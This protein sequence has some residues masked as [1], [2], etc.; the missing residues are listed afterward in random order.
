MEQSYLHKKPLEGFSRSE[1]KVLPESTESVVQAALCFLIF[2]YT[3]KKTVELPVLN[4]GKLLLKHW[5]IQ[6]STRMGDLIHGFSLNSYP[7]EQNSVS[8]ELSVWNPLYVVSNGPEDLEKELNQVSSTQISPDIIFSISEGPKITASVYSALNNQDQDFLEGILSHWLHGIQLLESHSQSP[9]YGLPILPE[10]EYQR[11]IYDWNNNVQERVEGKFDFEE[12][13][14]HVSKTPN[15]IAVI[16]GGESLTYRELQIRANQLAHYLQNKG[17]GPEVVAGIYLTRSIEFV[18][19]LVALKKSG[20]AFLPLDP[21]HP[22]DRKEYLIKNSRVPFIITT[23]RW[24]DSLPDGEYQTIVLEDIAGE[25]SKLPSHSPM[26]GLKPGNMSYLFFTSGSTGQP[27]GVM[28]T[29]EYKLKKTPIKRAT[30]PS[31]TEKVLLKSSTGFT[32]V[33]LETFSPL[34][35]GGQ[36]VVVPKDKDKDPEWLVNIIQSEAVESLCL[37]P[38]MLALLLLQKGF[39]QCTSIKKVLTVGESLPVSVQEDF[40]KALPQAQLVVYYGCT[41]APSATVRKIDPKEDYGDRVVLGKANVNR[42]I[43][44]LDEF[45]VPVPIGVPGE[46]FIGGT[47]SRGYIHNESLTAERFIPDTFSKQKGARMYQTGDL[48]R[49]LTD[50]SLEYI[51]RTDF[52][53]QIR[54]IRIEPGEIEGVLARHPMVQ[55]CVVLARE[56][57]PGNKQ[58]VA[59]WLAVGSEFPTSK[60]L[61]RYLQKS[62]PEYM[63]PSSFVR[64]DSFPLT[65]NGKIDRLAF[66]RPPKVNLDPLAEHIQ[67]RTLT[68]ERIARI[69]IKCLRLPESSPSK[70]PSQIHIHDNFFE[71]GGHSLIAAQLINQ[72][73]SDLQVEMPINQ[74]FESPTIAQLAAYVEAESA[75]HKPGEDKSCLVTVQSDGSQRPFFLVPGGGGGEAELIVYSRLI[76]LLGKDQP[77]YG[78][79]AHGHEGAQVPYPSVESIAAHYIEA[80]STIQPQGPYLI[81]GECIGGVVAY[82]MAQQL[83]AE[84]REVGL[85]V[86][87]DTIVPNLKK[88]LRYKIR[89][90]FKIQRI[91]IHRKKLKSLPLKNRLRYL[92]NLGT[93]T[94]KRMAEGNPSGHQDYIGNILKYRPQPYSGPITSIVTE[95]STLDIENRNWQNLTT[96]RLEIHKVP[97]THNTYLGEQVETTAEKLRECLSKAQAGNVK[98]G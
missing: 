70:G 63:T 50:G 55:Q 7:D 17:I 41:E 53:V 30:Q 12:F 71:V 93:K 65:P 84:G 88:S 95:D 52:Q 79:R 54:G 22:L 64:L 78:F 13:D 20:G 9:V 45:G 60:A 57:E 44:L 89:Q 69:W 66:P 49:F 15:K 72:I 36:I 96:G 58:L 25:L 2:R 46:I 34:N 21:D 27:K 18:V 75:D 23:R 4:K 67:P 43:Y 10:D 59:Y 32:L 19:A 6:E 61:R 73:R 97:G 51:G 92:F 14:E 82:E 83:V 47:I 28:M 80:L 29:M 38:S 90:L 8:G 76:Y 37:V 91:A 40:F 5:D 98:K 81:G 42:K 48:G 68:E 3:S 26:H 56:D 1:L 24:Q 94:R 77:V 11:M 74:L 33:L 86:L 35:S 16:S 87:M 39:D 62:L 31:K 85:L